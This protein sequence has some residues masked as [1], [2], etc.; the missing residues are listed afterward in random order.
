MVPVQVAAVGLRFGKGLGLVWGSAGLGGW[1]CR[2]G[3]EQL[4]A[5]TTSCCEG[6]PAHELAVTYLLIRT[7]PCVYIYICVVFFSQ[8][9]LAMSLGLADA[10][11]R[12]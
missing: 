10:A 4:E 6:T 2:W 1:G 8:D 5:P 9:N 7:L 3:S 11:R 12:G